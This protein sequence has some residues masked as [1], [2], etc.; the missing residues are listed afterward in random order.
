MCAAC[1]KPF[2]KK[3]HS[4]IYCS[5]SCCNSHQFKKAKKIIIERR[6]ETKEIKVQNFRAYEKIGWK[7]I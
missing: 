5:I 6:G 1:H 2:L 7:K 4:K 3:Q